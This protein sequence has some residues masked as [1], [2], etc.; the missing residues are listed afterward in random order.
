MPATLDIHT[1]QQPEERPAA[2]ER[3]AGGF[4]DERGYLNQIE[5]IL[6][7]GRRKGDR[8]GTGVLSVF[9]AQ[10]RFSLRGR[11]VDSKQFLI[12]VKGRQAPSWFSTVQELLQNNRMY[13]LYCCK[14]KEDIVFRNFSNSKLCKSLLQTN[15]IQV[16]TY[17]THFI[18][19]LN[20]GEQKTDFML[21]L[22]FE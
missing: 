7:H 8:T 2:E 20:E 11:C 15:T 17:L 9:G 22:I 10:C 16:S 18:H 12:H 19:N 5:D 13:L 14:E 3:T 21:R 6:Q 1:G 4:R